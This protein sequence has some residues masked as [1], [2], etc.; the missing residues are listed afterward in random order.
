MLR[1]RVTA[2]RI[3][4]SRRESMRILLA[5]I[6]A[7]F[8][9]S[10]AP[11]GITI[12]ENTPQRLVFSFEIGDYQSTEIPGD[13]DAKSLLSFRGQNAELGMAGEPILPALSVTIGVP[14]EGGPRVGFVSQQVKKI[15]LPNALPIRPDY[16]SPLNRSHPRFENPW[17]SRMRFSETRGLRT[18]QIVI[19]PFLYDPDSRTATVLLRGTCTIE[20][21][22]ALHAPRPRETGSFHEVLQQTLLNYDV[23]RGWFHKP[24]T[25]FRKALTARDLEPENDMGMFMI[26]DGSDELNEGTT[27]ENGVVKITGEQAISVFGEPR[28]FASL[29]LYGSRK[30]PLPDR[31]PAHQEIPPGA[32]LIPI[33]PFDQNDNGKMDSEDWILACVSGTSDWHFDTISRDYLFELNRYEDYR[34]YWLVSN[35]RG[36]RMDTFSQPESD[37]RPALER[38][39]HRVH[40][41][42]ATRLSTGHEGGTDWIWAKLTSGA[43]SFSLPLGLPGLDTTAPGSIR[44]LRKLTYQDSM[45]VS[46]GDSLLCPTCR[47]SEQWRTVAHWPGQTLQLNFHDKSSDNSG[48]YELEAIEVKYQ[49]VLS[50]KHHS[51]LRILS[52]IDESVSAY[53]IAELPEEKVYVFRIPLEESRTTIVDVVDA[54]ETSFSFTDTTGLGVQYIV[55]AESAVRSVDFSAH[56]RRRNSEYRV[57]HLASSSNRADYIVITHDAFAAE[58]ERLVRHKAESRQFRYPKVTLIEDVYREFSGGNFDPGAIRNFLSYATAF[59]TVKPEYVVLVGNGNYDHKGYVASEQNFIP[60]AQFGDKCI[61]DFF[62]YLSPGESPSSVSSTPDLFIGRLPVN[63]AGEAAAIVDKII[64]M[65]GE[66]RDRGAWR[67]RALLV[68]DDDMQGEKR[69]PISS[70]TPHHVSSERVADT[71]LAMRSSMDIRKVYLFEY[72]WNEFHEKPE[73][74]RALFNEINSGVGFVNYF[75]HGSLDVWADE[76]IFRNEMIASLTNEKRYPIITAFSCSVGTFDL[77]GRQC[78]SGALVRAQGRGA[79]VTVSSTRKAFA[80]YNETLAKSFYGFLVDGETQRT[81]GQAYAHA[82]LEGNNLNDNQKSYVLLGDPSLRMIRITDSVSLALYDIDDNRIDT[83]KALQSVKVKGT[84]M[85]DG[86]KNVTFGSAS[87]PAKAQIGLYNPQLDSVNRKDGGVGGK[88]SYSLPGT[89][90]FVGVTDVVNGAFEQMVF[91]PRR[92]TFEKPGVKLLAYAYDEGDALGVGRKSDVI[93]KGQ[94]PYSADDTLGPNIMIRTVYD[95]S[96]WNVAAGPANELTAMLPVE[97]AVSLYDESGIDVVGAGPDEGLTFEI[98]G[99]K[100]KQNVNH[101]F[102]FDEGDFKKGQ[103]TILIQEGELATGDHTLIVSAQDLLGNISRS[104]IGLSILDDTQFELGPVYTYPNPAPMGSTIRFYVHHSNNHA[105]NQ[106]SWYG[107]VETTIKIYTMSG[108]CIRVLKDVYRNGVPWN[109][110][111]ER[112]N[113]LPPNMYLWRV[114]AKVTMPSFTRTE[115][116]PVQKLIIHP[117]R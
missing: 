90:V 84:I 116:S 55:C 94:E 9:T 96:S 32:T 10:A 31:A 70:G 18:G 110:T 88:V 56:Q 68:A 112:G 67:N 44:I 7:C 104:E 81:V 58:A 99:V 91:L 53:T 108:R 71:I 103:A 57:H 74:S 42:R 106:V 47:S 19:R 63:T 114:T 28:A 25:G 85:R 62:V 60:T 111:D 107:D 50:M 1:S 51:L 11:A 39:E 59:W 45:L 54:S 36:V 73:A 101:K 17:L 13:G 49:R 14:S 33:L 89:P 105:N 29:A 16:Q 76:H 95:Q 12:I 23:A 77:P 40:Y 82:K 6:S 5:A 109:L 15:R 46:L 115:Q 22:P 86:V 37:G 34:H 43:P 100:P 69:D 79:S 93:F 98:E 38:V 64:E 26:G 24:A 8:I 87:A 48:Y 72:A 113:R 117:P 80:S 21:P 41:R 65:E 75:G 35:G 92:L 102:Q 61:E 20:F 52:P 2:L 30:T 4:H 27:Y 97:L 3:P 78:L 66:G 83:L